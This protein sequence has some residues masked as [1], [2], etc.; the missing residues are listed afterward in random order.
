MN[1]KLL[2]PLLGFNC[3]AC[4]WILAVRCSS[5]LNAGAF[6]PTNGYESLMAYSVWKIQN[7]LS[8]YEWPQREPFA[9]TLY[10]YL[11]Y[12]L[13]AH[14]LNCLRA[15][16]VG[17]LLAGRML[18]L[19][20]AC[21][22][23]AVLTSIMRKA[24]PEQTCKGTMPLAVMLASLTW[25]STSFLAWHALSLRPDVAAVATA[26]IGTLIFIYAV[27][28][29][30]KTLVATSGLFFYGCWAQ[31]QSTVTLFLGACLFLLISRE[32]R[33]L[34]MLAS[35]FAIPIL[36]TLW[37][38]GDQYRYSILIAPRIVGSF[39]LNA[40]VS[41]WSKALLLNLLVWVLATVSLA[42]QVRQLISVWINGL[43]NTGDIGSVTTRCM[44]ACAFVVGLPIATLLL[45][46][47]AAA[48]NHLLE[49]FVAASVLAFSQLAHLLVLGSRRT[50]QLER[51][52]VT[53]LA[54]LWL[55]YPS[56][57]I[58]YLLMFGSASYGRGLP[59]GQ[60]GL[61]SVAEL[62]QGKTPWHVQ[63]ASNELLMDRKAIASE[64]ASLAKP[65]FIRDEVFLLP[66]YATAGRYPAYNPDPVYEEA[67]VRRGI[68]TPS[69]QQLLRQRRFAS[70]ILQPEDPA[71]RD[72]LTSGYRVV[73]A[74]PRIGA[75]G[76]RLL[77]Y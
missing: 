9:L 4:A 60:F 15:S 19:L 75:K 28:R 44:M 39:S 72:A 38:G 53:V 74:P 61:N 40:A 77:V 50:T 51:F 45:S 68:M 54:F 69:L 24:C 21:L 71:L 12:A 23:A 65:L 1:K 73:P 67:A 20:F 22:G 14:L 35:S 43:Y 6:C 5:N 25:L 42:R 31:K 17:I 36:V 32:F 34:V 10:N 13:Y 18:T 76:F 56:L 41:E 11:F 46:K 52:A 48:K 47:E 26:C 2:Y 64:L 62:K 58:A 37:I 3:L 57:Q 27:T 70:V 66:W 49:V 8:L 29:H 33:L 7:H 59:T 55:A 16:G 30:S 63:L